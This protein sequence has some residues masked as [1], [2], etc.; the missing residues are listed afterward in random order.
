LANGICELPLEAAC[1]T[2]HGFNLETEEAIA[3]LGFTGAFEEKPVI[4]QMAE[5][6]RTPAKQQNLN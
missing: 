3:E 1:P 2:L 4:K 6:C 5:A